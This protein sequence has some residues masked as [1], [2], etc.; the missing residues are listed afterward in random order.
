M[1]LWQSAQSQEAHFSYYQFTPVDVNPANAIFLPWFLQRRGIYS[2]NY[3]AISSRPYRNLD[4]NVDAP[5][6]RGFRKQ[7]WVGVGIGLL[8]LPVLNG[9][10]LHVNDDGT[11]A[12][13]T[14][15]VL[16]GFKGGLAYHLSLDKNK[17]ASLL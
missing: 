16:T 5:I 17:H 9:S 6:I 8:V 7:D 10:G 14:T 11:P 13:G 2:D 1:L 15:Q 4:V 12:I 3:G